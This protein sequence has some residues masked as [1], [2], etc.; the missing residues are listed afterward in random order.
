M[1]GVEVSQRDG[2]PQEEEQVPGRRAVH[3]PV[4]GQTM[5]ELLRTAAKTTGGSGWAETLQ[6]LATFENSIVASRLSSQT[7]EAREGNWDV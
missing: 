1:A 6:P 5:Q 4:E 7:M 2:G 3:R